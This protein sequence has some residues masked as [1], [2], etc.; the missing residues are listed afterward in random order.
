MQ[1]LSIMPNDLF[2]ALFIRD[3]ILVNDNKILILFFSLYLINTSFFHKMYLPHTIHFS[4]INLQYQVL[5]GS[6]IQAYR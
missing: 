6:L 3:M 4:V 2:H 1:F 5:F